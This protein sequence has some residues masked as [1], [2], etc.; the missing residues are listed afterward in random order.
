[1]W[2]TWFQI[3]IFDVRF[4]GDSVWERFCKIYQFIAFIIFAAVGASFNPGG[5][6]SDKNYMIYQT[7]A[8]ILG[9]TRWFLAI[10][11]TII[12]C[13]VVPKYK[14]LWLP[15]LLLVVTFLISGA[16]MFAV[17]VPILVE[18]Q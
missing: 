15:F 11:Y 10:Q 1:M 17:R 7:M 5:E 14:K 2:S 13:F 8:V 18:G 9:V 3:T 4:A 16:G 6:G 12:A